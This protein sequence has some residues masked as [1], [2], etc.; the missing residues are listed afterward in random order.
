MEYHGRSG[1]EE[2]IELTISCCFF[3]EC[4][5]CLKGVH[6][7]SD[8]FC[9]LFVFFGVGMQGCGECVR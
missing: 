5:E 8:F 7:F 1:L 4:E 9:F 2:C 6:F 3:V